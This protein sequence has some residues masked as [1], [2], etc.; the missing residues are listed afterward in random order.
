MDRMAEVICRAAVCPLKCDLRREDCGQ[1]SK[2]R[3]EHPN[4]HDPKTRTIVSLLRGRVS[5][6]DRTERSQLITHFST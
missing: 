6:M 3:A 4:D 5:G 2:K 1:K